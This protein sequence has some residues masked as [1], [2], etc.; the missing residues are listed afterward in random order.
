[1]T[2]KEI[3]KQQDDSGDIYLISQGLFFRGYNQGAAFLHEAF[4][5]RILSR[6]M[7]SCCGRVFYAGFPATNA[8]AMTDKALSRGG[9]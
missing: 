5:Y 7:K 9:R 4:G 3:L 8:K 2:I 6:E 1:M